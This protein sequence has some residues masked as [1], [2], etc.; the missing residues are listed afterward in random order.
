MQ[1]DTLM[2]DAL[3][4]I[5]RRF[6]SID[7]GLFH[8]GGTRILGLTVTMDARQGAEALML[9]DPQVSIPIHYDDYPQIAAVR[10]QSPGQHCR[11]EV[12]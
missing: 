10:L 6:A 9:I 7:L 3:R 4:E 12:E 1:H 11:F 8:L 5:P 2:H